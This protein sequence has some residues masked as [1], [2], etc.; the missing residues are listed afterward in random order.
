MTF[1]D[2]AVKLIGKTKKDHSFLFMV[3]FLFLSLNLTNYKLLTH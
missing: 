2:S 3:Q 1:T